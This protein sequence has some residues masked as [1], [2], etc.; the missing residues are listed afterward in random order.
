MRLVDFDEIVDAL[1]DEEEG[2][3]GGEDVLPELGE[4]LDG[5]AA[6]GPHQH[7]RQH[8]HHTQIHT[9]SRNTKN[10][11]S[12]RTQSLQGKT[13]SL[14]KTEGPQNSKSHIKN[15]HIVEYLIEDEEV[16]PIGINGCPATNE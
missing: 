1:H 5:Y 9:R 13:I 10:S 16:G 15:P 6:V 7:H 4:P 3:E 14:T 11:I 12:Y 8:Q 2:R